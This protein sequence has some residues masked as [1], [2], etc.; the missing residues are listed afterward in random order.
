MRQISGAERNLRP[1][2]SKEPR[3]GR[4]LET[5]YRHPNKAAAV[6]ATVPDTIVDDYGLRFQALQ[7]DES[8]CT[9]LSVERRS[10]P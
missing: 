2:P 3:I 8:L 6:S 1:R 5:P 4:R 10:E 9:S 7:R